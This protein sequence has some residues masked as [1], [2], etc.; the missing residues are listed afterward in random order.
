MLGSVPKS[1]KKPF[2]SLMKKIINAL[3]PD[4]LTEKKALTDVTNSFNR[5]DDQV[6]AIVF[7]SMHILCYLKGKRDTNIHVHTIKYEDVLSN[8]KDE[9]EKIVYFLNKQ[10]DKINYSSCLEAMNKDSQEKS[11]AI[12]KEKLA[13]FKKK[14]TVTEELLDKIDRYFT[15][16]GLPRSKNFDSAFS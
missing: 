1:R 16:Y 13:A 15:D 3:S 7:F 12:S 6:L 14:N 11:E 10:R 8:P 5:G 9:L 2:G 4:P